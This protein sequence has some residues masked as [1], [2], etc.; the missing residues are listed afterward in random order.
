MD[1]EGRRLS[2]QGSVRR[3]CCLLLRVEEGGAAGHAEDASSWAR[4]QLSK[5]NMSLPLH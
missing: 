1:R 3:V 4:T 5:T 2:K